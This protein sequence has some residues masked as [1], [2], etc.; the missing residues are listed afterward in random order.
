MIDTQ[1]FLS[2]GSYGEFQDRQP[3]EAGEHYG[4]KSHRLVTFTVGIADGDI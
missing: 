1:E 2:D 4:Y 3:V